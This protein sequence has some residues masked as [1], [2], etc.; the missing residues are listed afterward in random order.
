MSEDQEN[1]VES[2]LKLLIKVVIIFVTFILIVFGACATLLFDANAQ[3]D[4]TI[5]Q[6]DKTIDSKVDKA[7]VQIIFKHYSK[8]NSTEHNRL[9]GKI[10]KLDTKIGSMEEKFIELNVNVKAVLKIIEESKK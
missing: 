2:I 10:E 5:A 3:Q 4:V 7:E 6:Q 9:D 1:K 8:E